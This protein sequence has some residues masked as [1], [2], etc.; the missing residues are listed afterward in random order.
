MLLGR[1]NV[2]LSSASL[3]GGSAGGGS[4]HGLV[5][6]LVDALDS[7]SSGVIRESSSLS[8]ATIH[9]AMQ[10]KWP[11]YQHFAEL[12]SNGKAFM[13][14]DGCTA[15]PEMN[16]AACCFE[17]DYYYTT[18]AVSRPE[19][20]KRLRECIAQHHWKLLPW[21]YWLAVRCFGRRAWTKK[22]DPDVSIPDE[23]LHIEE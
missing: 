22:F 20:D 12:V 6:K 10:S 23:I 21:L 7:E 2:Q 19:A 1:P 9:T 18:H 13:Q 5:A 3:F 15:A 17:H 11:T 14:S 4:N 8:E 16:F